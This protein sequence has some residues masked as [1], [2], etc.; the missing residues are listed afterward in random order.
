MW[1]KEYEYALR[2][3]PTVFDETI[4]D[5]YGCKCYKEFQYSNSKLM[6]TVGFNK[7]IRKLNDM[8]IVDAIIRECK[9]YDRLLRDTKVI[10]NKM[11]NE[12]SFYIK[13]NGESY[14]DIFLEGGTI[15][16]YGFGCWIM[17]DY[18]AKFNSDFEYYI[19][20]NLHLM[21]GAKIRKSQLCWAEGYME[22]FINDNCV[23]F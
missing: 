11:M 9:L 19:K 10:G 18:L 8:S 15:S 16:G 21:W 7:S 13:K 14:R 12:P 22:G 23:I 20:D 2:I 6:H 4:F 3:F 17:P 1:L 5:E